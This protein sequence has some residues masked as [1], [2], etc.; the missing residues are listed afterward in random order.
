MLASMVPRPLLASPPAEVDHVTAAAP[1]EPKVAEN[2]STVLPD[3]PFALQPTQLVSMLTVPGAMLNV[4]LDAPF[5]VPPAE[6]PPPQP[7]STSVKENTAAAHSRNALEGHDFMREVTD[8][9]A[10]ARVSSVT[11]LYSIK[12][13]EAFDLVYR[14]GR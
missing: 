3:E 14:F 4:P 1:P 13:S 8:A 5:D 6:M 12:S 10:G 11:R 7:A 2:C 9:R